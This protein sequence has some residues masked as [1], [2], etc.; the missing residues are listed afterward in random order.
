MLTVNNGG[1]GQS[2]D[3]WLMHPFSSD[4]SVAKWAL[5][6]GLLLLLCIAWSRV[7]RLVL[8]NA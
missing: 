8:D 1:L 3:N 6:V 4:M 2:V 7:I 5:F